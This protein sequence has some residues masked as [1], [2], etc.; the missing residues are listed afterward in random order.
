MTLALIAIG[1]PLLLLVNT[2]QIVGLS[3]CV[4]HPKEAP[5]CP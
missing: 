3:R 2:A 1:A 5:K 4:N